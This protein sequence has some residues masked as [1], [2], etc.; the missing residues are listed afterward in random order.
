MA[1]SKTEVKRISFLSLLN[2]AAIWEASRLE[3]Q[4]P[5]E[6]AQDWLAQMEDDGFMAE[7]AGA[8]RPTR[9]SGGRNGTSSGRGSSSRSSNRGGGGSGGMRDPNGPPTDK[10]VN[11]VL[12]R[13]DDYTEDDLYDMTKKEV[14]DLIEDLLNAG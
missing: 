12:S 5:Y 10:Q 8:S 7:E 11:L 4:G 6:I 2:S 3:S 9:G 14:S 1:L 13:S